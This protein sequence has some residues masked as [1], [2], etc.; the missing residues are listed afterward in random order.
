MQFEA[1][2]MNP[3]F[4]VAGDPLAYITHIEHAVSMLSPWGILVAIA[5]PS[6]TYRSDR[7]SSAFRA[8]VETRGGWEA[9]PENAF[10]A[11]GT[12][13]STVMLWLR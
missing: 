3:P 4:A 12:E 2:L 11:S 13:V 9:L 8:M 1:I 5:P 6:F 7:R 10:T